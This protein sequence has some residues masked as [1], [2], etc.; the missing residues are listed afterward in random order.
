MT[1]RVSI[2]GDGQMG[3]VL[4]DAL[5]ERGVRVRLWGPF[6]DDI[7]AL[8]ADRRAPRRLPGFVLPD[9]VDVT[10]DDAAVLDG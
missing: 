5:A 9:A 1:T 3:L 2:V 6:P 10:A 4:A 7:E 8:A